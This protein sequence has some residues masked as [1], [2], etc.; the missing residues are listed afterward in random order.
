[1]QLF[2]DTADLS[3]IKSAVD[4]GIIDGITTNPSIISKL[5]NVKFQDHI[6][7]ICD[8]IDGDVSLEVNSSSFD[9]MMSEAYN[10]LDIASNIVIKLP[11][12][13]DGIK[14][15]RHLSKREIKVNMTLCFSPNQAIV[16]A[17]A[18][19]YYVSPF[20]GRVDDIGYDSIRLIHDIKKI[21]SNYNFT[22]KILAASIRHPYH[23]YQCALNGADVV[24]IPWK[25]CQQLISHPLTDKG[26]E[27]FRNDFAKSCLI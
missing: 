27:I 16:A 10:L 13:Y 6:K 26:L 20:L 14:L 17:K 11:I 4:L 3:E 5:Q 22:T 25:L 12:T 24:T 15:C 18:G 19:A 1:M 23:V 21:Y 8:V 9:D 2:L 7:Q